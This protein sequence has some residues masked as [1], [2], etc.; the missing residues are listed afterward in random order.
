MLEPDRG[1]FRPPLDRV[2][3]PW[4][5]DACPPSDLPVPRKVARLRAS[6]LV[7]SRYF[8]STPMTPCVPSSRSSTNAT[9]NG[10]GIFL[11]PIASYDHAQRACENGLRPAHLVASTPEADS[12]ARRGRPARRLQHAHAHKPGR[13]AVHANL[14]RDSELRLAQLARRYL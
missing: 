6:G 7:R 13:D 10:C 8:V 1:E 9:S 11:A 4:L 5:E 12:V 3:R 14:E 2:D